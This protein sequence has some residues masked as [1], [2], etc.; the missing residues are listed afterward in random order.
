MDAFVSMP[1][2]YFY[3]NHI[4][5]LIF[6]QHGFQFQSEGM[7]VRRDDTPTRLALDGAVLNLDVLAD[8]MQAGTP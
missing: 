3:A 4:S 6:L 7:L 2:I 1:N 5:A 8:V